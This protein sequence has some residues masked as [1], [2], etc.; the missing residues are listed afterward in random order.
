MNVLKLEDW[1]ANLWITG[2]VNRNHHLPTDPAGCKSRVS[3]PAPPQAPQVTGATTTTSPLCV[4]YFRRVLYI[5]PTARLCFQTM[6]DNLCVSRKQ[7]NPLHLSWLLIHLDS[8]QTMLYCFSFSVLFICSSSYVACLFIYLF[9]Y[10]TEFPLLT[11]FFTNLQV[12]DSTW[13]KIEN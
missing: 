12:S 9:I 8:F 7:F 1:K 3:V 10:L 2:S 6:F 4:R 5:K 11:F 13:L